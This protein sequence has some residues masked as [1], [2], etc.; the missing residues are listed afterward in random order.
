MD[1][2]VCATPNL[3]KCDKFFDPEEDGLKRHWY[4]HTR[5]GTCFMNPPYGREI[6]KW[7][8]KAHQEAANNL[9][10]GTVALLPAKI[11]TNWWWDYCRHWEVRFLKGRLKFQGADVNAPFPSA[12]VI[13]GAAP[14]T[15][16]WDWKKEI[17]TKETTSK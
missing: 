8:A 13:F 11:D 12:V 17:S 10:V 16:Y 7:V 15:M 2:D 14:R 3:A 5:T 1:L 4:K 6:P 9:A